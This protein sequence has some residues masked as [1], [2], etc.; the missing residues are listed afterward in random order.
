MGKKTW[1]VENTW[2]CSSCR[3]TNKGRYM[4][5]QSCGNPKE[6]H[7]KY[8]TSGNYTA[9]A[10]TDPDL[11]RKAKAGKNWEC[12]YCGNS[13]RNLH[14]ECKTCGGPKTRAA[15][16]GVPLK[17]T[18]KSGK[19]FTYGH[20]IPSEA[21]EEGLSVG[22]V[23]VPKDV[24]D[25]VLDSV[26]IPEPEPVPERVF[27]PHTGGLRDAP[28]SY[29]KPKKP[30]K[31]KKASKAKKPSPPRGNGGDGGFF[32][33]FRKVNWQPII[34]VTLAI[35]AFTSVIGLLVWVFMPQKE[36]VVVDDVH[37]VYTAHLQ[38]RQLNHGTD[39]DG[40]MPVGAF[41]VD[42]VTR[43]HGT[44]NC[45]P[46][47][48]NCHQVTDYCSRQCNCRTIAPTC[49]T[50]CTDNGNGFSTCS[51]S[52]SGGGT[53]CDTCREP[54]G[55][56][57]ECSTCYDQCPVYDEWCEFDYY[58]WPTIDTERTQGHDHNMY[59]PDLEVQE[60]PPAPQRIVRE[61]TYQVTFE[62]DEGEEWE[63][64]P[65]GVGDFN[66]FDTGDNWLIEVNHV[67]GVYPQHLE[68]T[69]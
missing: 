23:K 27:L 9:P 58:T 69:E 6:K 4:E 57:E 46:H 26:P 44:E 13:V 5:C 38:Q 20:V 18:D 17:T 68:T 16:K 15:E 49:R 31:S 37:W 22:Q 33:R 55:S 3:S 2:K 54:C 50:T 19:E 66:R 21:L 8:D 30:K 42:C 28:K 43:Q 56:H 53:T 11:I 61:H 14:G 34:V 41:N 60:N 10:V 12:G 45:N 36:H 65:E 39:W 67:G 52:C 59:E 1:I 51:E 35:A 24:L 48:C 64:E 62:N 40:N 63:Y 29:L 25:N 7:E 47:D 32:N